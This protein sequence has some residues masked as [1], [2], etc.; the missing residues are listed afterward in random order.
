M[1]AAEVFADPNFRLR[2]MPVPGQGPGAKPPALEF[3]ELVVIIGGHGAHPIAEEEDPIKLGEIFV[4]LRSMS[5]NYM[6][7]RGCP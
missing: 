5:H 7:V 3:E 4:V 1:K 6:A 2:A